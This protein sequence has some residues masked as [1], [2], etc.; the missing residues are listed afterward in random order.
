MTDQVFSELIHQQGRELF[1]DMPWRSEPTGYY[2]LVSELM[3]QQ[4]QVDRVLPKFAQFIQK[5]P[6]VE[7]LASASLA[8]VL[9]VWSGL[10]YNRRAKYLHMAAGQIVREYEGVV[11]PGVEDLVKLPGIGKNTAGAIAAYVYNAPVIF[12]ETNIRTVYLHHF[13]SD[14]SDITDVQIAQKLADTLDT[15]NPR[16]FYW[17]LM[18][19][20][21]WLKRNGVKNIHKAAEYRKQS[22]LKGSVREV[23]GQILRLLTAGDVSYEK[24][25]SELA[26]DDRFALAYEGLVREKLIAEHQDKVGLTK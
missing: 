5:F 11:P 26:I 9:T 10:G 17:A 6:S 4:T 14:R 22:P 1:R 19:Y 23:R 21:S 25:R 20:G 2:V 12:V 7:A 8:D 18:D 15:K 16:E 3:L 13:Y 24:L